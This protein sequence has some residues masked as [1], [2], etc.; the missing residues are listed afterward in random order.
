MRR[1]MSLSIILVVA[2]VTAIGCRRDPQAPA[3][4]EIELV[5]SPSPP[6][7]GPAEVTVKLTD[8]AGEPLKGAKVELE[9]NMNHAGMKPSFATL[10][11]AAPG[12]Y[13]GTI[14]FTMGGDWFVLVTAKTTEGRSI[15]RKI[16]VPGVRAP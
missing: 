6:A 4:A 9:G 8:A 5:F 10:A 11:E 7:V 2:L 12:R 3:G 14:H 16:D 13:T 1:G 15:E